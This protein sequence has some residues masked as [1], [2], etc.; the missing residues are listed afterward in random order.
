MPKA[1]VTDVQDTINLNLTDIPENKIQKM[2]TRAATTLSL[3]LNR[4]INPDN[5]AEAEKEFITL[6]ASIYAICYLTGGSSVGLNFSIGDQNVTVAN[7]APPLTV[8]QQELERV[9][10]C[11]KKPTLRSV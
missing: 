4:Q 6:L 7:S 5:C 11:L 2:I 1:T 3:E 8:L 10:G 9:L